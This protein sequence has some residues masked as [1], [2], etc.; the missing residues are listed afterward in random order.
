MNSPETLGTTFPL[1]RAAPPLLAV[2]AWFKNTVCAAVGHEAIV[3]GTV[4]DLDRPEACRDFETNVGLYLDWLGATPRIIA[5][6]L[7]P[8]FHST[9]EAVR[10]AAELGA[11]TLPVQH[12]H[13]HVAAVCAEHGF[14][15]PVLGLALD[16]VGLGEDGSAWGGELLRVEGA[17][18]ERLGHLLPLALPGGDRAAREPWRMAA[19][20]LHSL[21]R[22]GE[23]ARR[24]ADEAGAP[25]IAAMLDRKL[26][27]PMTS[28]AGRVFDAA[29]GMLGLSRRMRFEAEAAIALEKAATRHVEA[30]GWPRPLEWAIDGANRLDLRPALGRLAPST[31]VD[32]DAAAFHAAFADGLSEWAARAAAGTGIG[33]I[34]FGGGCFL[35]RLIGSRVAE[36]LEAKGLTVMKPLRCSP[37]DTAVALGQAWIATHSE[38]AR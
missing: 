9:R 32:A 22:G 5:H 38:T 4:G 2:G 21:G 25:T 28:S 27:S 12:H 11:D 15:G 10:L 37:G 16:G 33:R 36:N 13:A 19:A 18:Y 29:A 8:D 34:A 6:D 14:A 24:Y 20:V 26:N 7:H 1:K 23:I 35:N 3:S 17:R 31:R 30:E